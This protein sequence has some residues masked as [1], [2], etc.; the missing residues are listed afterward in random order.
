M[1]GVFKLNIDAVTFA[2]E[3][4]YGVGAIIRDYRGRVVATK[5]KK[6]RGLLDLLKAKLM[7]VKKRLRLAVD[8]GIRAITLEGDAELVLDSFEESTMDL[9]HNGTILA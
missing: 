9:S 3:D 4:A 1:L 6:F 2:C 5:A 7:M 8:L